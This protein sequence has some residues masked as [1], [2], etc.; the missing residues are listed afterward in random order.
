[1]ESICC[2]LQQ[3]TSVKNG[4]HGAQSSQL[5]ESGGLGVGSIRIHTVPMAAHATEG[6]GLQLDSGDYVCGW[7][8][9]GK[10]LI[11]CG[12]PGRV[13]TVDLFHAI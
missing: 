5:I 8:G 3:T 1:M 10:C 6:F 11:G 2:R 4:A 7:L 12:G 9:D 13:R